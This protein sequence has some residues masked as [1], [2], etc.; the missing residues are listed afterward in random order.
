[1]SARVISCG[2]GGRFVW[3]TAYHLH[4]LSVSKY[5]EPLPS[6]GLR[7]CPDLYR[8]WFMDL[9]LCCITLPSFIYLDPSDFLPVLRICISTS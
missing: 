5:L 6:E 1:M 2:K 4:V 8:D 3:L 7:V 9:V